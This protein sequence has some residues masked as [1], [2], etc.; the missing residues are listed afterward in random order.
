MLLNNSAFDNSLRDFNLSLDIEV[1]ANFMRA[2]EFSL[3]YFLTAP[4]PKIPGQNG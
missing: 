1:V 4:L 3:E 2:T